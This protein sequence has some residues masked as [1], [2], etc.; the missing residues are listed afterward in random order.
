LSADV[1]FVKNR[2]GKIKYPYPYG[3]ALILPQRDGV[4]LYFVWKNGIL[5]YWND[6][7]KKMTFLYLIPVKRNFTITQFF[8]FQEP[9]ISV[10]HYSIIPIV[11][12][13]K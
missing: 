5:E 12:E 1:E 10:F 6:D 7:L 13:A 4:I 3:Q 9:N 11:S 8:I 2:G